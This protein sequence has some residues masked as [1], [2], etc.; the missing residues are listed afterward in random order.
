MAEYSLDIFYLWLVPV[1]LFII[2]P[3][4]I[5]LAH[6]IGRFSTKM[7]RILHLSE[8][9][10]DKRIY[11]DALLADLTN[12]KNIPG[13]TCNISST[14]ICIQNLPSSFKLNVNKLMVKLMA[15]DKTFTL[16]IIPKWESL[17]DE[18][19]SIGAIISNPP[20]DWL[21]FVKVE[22]SIH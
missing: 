11:T 8:Q 12:G 17:Q 1:F 13:T 15:R 9:R 14:G 19:K 2:L 7:V 16:T 4:T 20:D 10:T 18:V 3:L 21:E 6:S 5:L 22:Q